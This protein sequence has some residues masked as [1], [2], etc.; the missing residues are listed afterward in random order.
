MQNQKK[1]NRK[2]WDGR[3]G[4]EGEGMKKRGPET[5][6]EPVP[7]GPQPGILPIKTIQASS[8]GGA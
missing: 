2:G 5:G 6:F 1:I 7:P 4:T 3:G 8:G